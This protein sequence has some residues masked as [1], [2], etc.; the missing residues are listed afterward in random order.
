MHA[1][2]ATALVL[3]TNAVVKTS[4]KAL[5]IAT[6]TSLTSVAFAMVRG[7]DADKRDH[8]WHLR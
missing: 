6:A 3:F 8:G 5:A 4:L 2:F 7:V 1:A